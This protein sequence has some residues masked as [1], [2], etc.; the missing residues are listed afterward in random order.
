[1]R[2]QKI[3]P[4]RIFSVYLP[5]SLYDKLLIRAGKGSVST[6][7]K[8]MLEKELV[9]E[10]QRQKEQLKQQLIK[11]YQ[12]QTKNKKLREGAVALEAAQFEDF[13]EKRNDRQKK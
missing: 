1:M 4:A 5:A 6:F 8:G 13:A 3:E 10:E 7:I 2:T 12:T 11:G 9:N